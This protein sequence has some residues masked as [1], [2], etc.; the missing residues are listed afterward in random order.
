MIEKIL[1]YQKA[2]ADLLA[3]QTELSGSVDRKKAVEIKEIMQNQ[4]TRLLTLE[5]LAEKATAAY[6]KATVKYEEYLKKLEVFEKEV[7]NADDGKVPAYEKAYKDFV[8]VANALEKEIAQMYTQVQQINREYEEIIKKSKVDRERF[9]KFS[10]AYSKLK[11]EKEPAIEALK[12]KIKDMKKDVDAKL[13]ERYLQKREGKLFPVF[14][15]LTSNKCEGCRMEVSAS[16][17]SSMKNNQY[18]VIECENC[19]RYIYQK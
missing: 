10:T 2:E 4:H 3:L 14:V 18:G 8:A 17:L 15:T 1:E 11:A 9:N 7:A 5:K 6:K 19:G 16:K 12:N 13:L